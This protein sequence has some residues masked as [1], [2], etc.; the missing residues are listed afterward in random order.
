MT[1]A[2]S[3]WAVTTPM[4][5]ATAV[6]P[7]VGGFAAEAIG[8]R[9]VFLGSTVFRAL[10]LYVLFRAVADTSQ[11]RMEFRDLLPRGRSAGV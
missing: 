5:V 2:L 7:L 6:G 11:R 8:L 4:G 1:T 9:P 10:G 3:M